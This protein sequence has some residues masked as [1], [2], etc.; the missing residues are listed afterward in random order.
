MRRNFF[1]LKEDNVTSS[2]NDDKEHNFIYNCFCW[3]FTVLIWGSLIIS[4]Y[5]SIS[6]ETLDRD[7]QM[8]FNIIL[9]ISYIVYLILEFC[10]PT[11]K[12]LYNKK[13]GEEMYDKM[14]SLFKAHP[15]II[16]HCE[17]YHYDTVHYISRD[18]DGHTHHETRTEKRITYTEGYSIPYYSSRDVSGLFYLNCDEAIIKQKYYIKLELKEEINFADEISYMDYEHYKDQFWRRNRFRDVYMDFNERRTI[19]GLIQYNLIKIGQNEPCSVNLF[20]FI[21]FSL[22]GICEFY[23]I[24]I[25]KFFVYQKYKIRKIISTRYDLNQPD[26]ENKYSQLAPQLNLINQ[27]YTYEPDSYNYVNHEINVDLPTKEELERA[28]QY[29]NKIP[30]YKISSGQE[31]LKDGVIIDNPKYSNF[32]DNLPPENFKSV[33]GNIPLNEDQINAEGA[34]P[35]GFGEP[36]SEQD[37]N[38]SPQSNNESMNHLDV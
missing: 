29:K 16:F 24:Y 9:F 19:P 25:N 34:P 2:H 10:S 14:G 18:K 13:S 22:L 36:G 15:N 30:D 4:I 5:Y 33:S 28:E 32:N 20:W 26:Y 12:Y 37:D 1:P 17:C 21:L 8:L 31:Q 35:V 23:K 3:F 11:A 7:N 6:I 27:Q 38:N